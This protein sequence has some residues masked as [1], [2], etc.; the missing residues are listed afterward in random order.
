MADLMQQARELL[1]AEYERDGI[2]YVPDC[3]RREAM[4]TEIEHLAVRAIAAALRAAPEGPAT[5]YHCAEGIYGTLSRL[6]R[7]AKQGDNKN[8]LQGQTMEEAA[9]FIERALAAR[10]QGVKD[11]R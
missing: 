11:G 9:A 5:H 1:A 3:I 6:R 2:T 10:P 8:T 7:Y 4:L